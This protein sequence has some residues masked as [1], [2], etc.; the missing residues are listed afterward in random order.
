MTLRD[1]KT[2]IIFF[3]PYS[4]FCLLCERCEGTQEHVLYCRVLQYIMPN[5]V[6]PHHEHLNGT[7]GHQTEFTQVYKKYLTI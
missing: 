2:N 4:T 1:I 6:L 3:Y 7:P 5:I